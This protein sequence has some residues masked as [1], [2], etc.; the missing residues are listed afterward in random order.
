MVNEET[1]PAAT[2]ARLEERVATL[3]RVVADRSRLLRQVT[4]VACDEDVMNISR[5]AAGQ[6]PIPRAGFGLRGWRE[7]TSTTMGDVDKTMAELWRAAA[8]PVL[9]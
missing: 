5:L 2:I 6:P 8:L 3:E 7:T 1:D 4:R 9:D